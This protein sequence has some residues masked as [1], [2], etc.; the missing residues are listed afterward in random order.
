MLTIFEF[1]L[2]YQAQEKDFQRIDWLPSSCSFHAK[3]K[4]HSG[5]LYIKDRF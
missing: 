2:N 1:G 3:V 5:A 4:F